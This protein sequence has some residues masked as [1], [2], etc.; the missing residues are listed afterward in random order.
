MNLRFQVPA[1]SKGQL[2]LK[3]ILA[4]QRKEEVP[5]EGEDRF[6]LQR[7]AREAEA[8]GTTLFQQRPAQGIGETIEN[9]VAATP[10][11]IAQVTPSVVRG[12]EQL[13]EDAKRKGII[14]A[15]V[16]SA[17]GQ[18]PSVKVPDAIRSIA[19]T[20]L[21]TAGG[22]L[23]RGNPLESIA[24]GIVPESL[25]VKGAAEML[26]QPD[27]I[28]PGA[29]GAAKAARPLL[30]AGREAAE[31][32]IER[33]PGAL[34]TLAREEGGAV[35]L[36]RNEPRLGKQP[37]EPAPVAETLQAP[38]EPMQGIRQE[39]EG[40][41]S[42]EG[43]KAAPE[44]G[45]SLHSRLEY[46][47][48]LPASERTRMA[49][50]DYGPETQQALSPRAFQDLAYR[51]A[52]SSG[53]RS[54][55]KRGETW[56]SRLERVATSQE[57]AGDVG[58]TPRG[59]VEGAPS[60]GAAEPPRR[61]PPDEPPIDVPP[62]DAPPPVPPERIGNSYMGDFRPF[63]EVQ[64]E[65]VTTD[66]K[67]KQWLVGKTGINPSIVDSDPVAKAVVAYHRQEVALR[68]LVD[69]ALA[70]SLDTHA[71]RVTGRMGEV[72]PIDQNTGFLR[73]TE[74]PWQDVFSNPGTY[75]LTPETRAYIDDFNRV[76]REAEDLRVSHGLKPLS[77]TS[78]EG[79]YYVPRQTKEV[80]GI[81][82][83]RPSSPK[84]QRVYDEALQ[85]YQAGV[86]YDTN[87]RATLEIHLRAAYR[88][89]L[90]KQM[91]DWVME[92]VKFITPKELV[93]EAIRTRATS[94]IERLRKAGNEVRRLRVP[95]EA[96]GAE[97]RT[98][99]AQLTKQRNAAQAELLAARDEY[100]IAKGAYKKA[101]ESA[102]KRE[103][104]PGSLF[105]L[106]EDEIPIATWRNR[107]LPLEQAKSLNEGVGFLAKSNRGNLIARGFENLG[108]TMRF[109]A[110]VGD[111]A[112]P[113]IQGQPTLFRNPVVWGR[114]TARHY[115]AF[116]DP[117]V[118]PRFIKD[119]IE[120]F[121][122]MARYGIPV[123]D[124]EFFAAL[125]PG[126][127]FSP[128]ELIKNLPK[129]QEARRMFQ[130]GGRQ[131]FGRFQ[132][133]YNMGLSALRALQW[134]AL[135]PKF[136]DKAELAAHIRNLTGGLDPAA[137]G[138]GPSQR[139]LESMWLAFSP[140][141]LRSTI[142]LVADAVTKPTTQRGQES[143][144][145]LASWATGITG[146]FILTGIALSKDWETEIKPGLNPLGGKKFLSHQINGDWIGVGGQLRALT[147]VLARITSAIAPGGEPAGG[148]I[149]GG[150]FDNPLIQ[151]WFYRAP[152]GLNIGLPLGE[153]ATGAN[154][155]PFEN[156]DTLP[157]LGKHLGTA[158]LPFSVQG[159][160]E[161]E[162][163]TTT[164]LAL[165]GARTSPQRPGDSPA[166]S[167]EQPLRRAP[168]PSQR[169]LKDILQRAA[170]PEP[171]RR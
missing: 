106:A 70:S 129:G 139:A 85:G 22:V 27:I 40:I 156:I 68:E 107:F 105:G 28:I 35:R 101:L 104:A 131:T 19:K 30:R 91:D 155:Y 60:P 135:K 51:R 78:E 53:T 66:N 92:N 23:P 171:A 140:R 43:A 111:F 152:P 74:R 17:E 29:G 52:L 57:A 94:A 147:Q 124:P 120:T 138:V 12:Q 26:L 161:G 145:V 13:K 158:S 117:S 123:G 79:W 127:S 162:Q 73:G 114:M 44:W 100:G 83:R 148:L 89:I 10:A 88:E 137:L 56:R 61:V 37:V 151:A 54:P 125:K 76:V 36:S 80:R 4:Q 49:L 34:R 33:A 42:V 8:R 142:A 122:E 130:A 113:F 11:T 119:H 95:R 55:L 112:M 39:A 65:V 136:A 41:R 20:L 81:E 31:T 163:A 109:L 77:T 141:L 166:P 159:R 45:Q 14:R 132:S 90:E 93:P 157:D 165:M 96:Q 150:L 15:W 149:G 46:L 98:I 1:R 3:Q 24:D 82:I 64:S 62:T 103:I 59:I 128:G 25:G 16:E 18:F 116:F 102:R 133:S 69:T 97:A 58:V 47:D 32:A 21:S 164:L 86:K 121:N 9:I 2:R 168:Q 143:I 144:R 71:E 110:S 99:R 7:R 146:A 108:N 153:F 38:R 169:R 118:Y 72:I 154:V 6:G 75:R 167:R 134:E 115:Q 5:R 126:Q 48:S 84:L 50:A 67:V 170:T 63:D 160:L 87:P